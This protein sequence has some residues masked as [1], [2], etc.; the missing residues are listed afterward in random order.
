MSPA[1]RSLRKRDWPRGLYETRPGYFVWREPGVDGKQ[2][3]LGAMPLAQARH[4]ALM[5]NDLIAQ[6]QA[7]LVERLRGQAHTVAEL[8][9]ELTTLRSQ[10]YV[11]HVRPWGNAPVGSPV[12][13][14]R[15]SKAFTAAR[16]LAGIQDE[17]DGKAAPTFHEIRSLCKRLYD[18]Q[19]GVDTKALLGHADEKTAELYA[20]VRGSELAVV[21]VA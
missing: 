10:H 13:V 5:A 20:K 18:K 21:K 6:R 7:T 3:T 19:G 16:Q 15:I 9:A 11:H 14:D 4:E 2:H 17:L 8:L 12:A 1:R